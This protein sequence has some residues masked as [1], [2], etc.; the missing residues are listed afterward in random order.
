M[1]GSLRRWVPSRSMALRSA[2]A[3]AGCGVLATCALTPRPAASTRDAL[4]TGTYRIDICRGGCRDLATD[5]V[6]ARGHLVIEASAYSPAELPQPARKYLEDDIYMRVL[7]EELLD[8]NACFA[9]T[10]VTDAHSYAGS[11]QVGITLAAREKGDSVI[12]DLFHSPDAGYYVVLAAAGGELRG[13][14]QSWGAGDAAFPADS[15]RAR[16][17]GPPDRGLCIRAAE[18]AAAERAAPRAPSRP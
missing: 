18:A 3:L 14:G 6:L 17:I 7:D 9:L 11:E 12:V 10:R 2:A 4:P 1:D 15:V 8:P 16:R 13:R 5:T